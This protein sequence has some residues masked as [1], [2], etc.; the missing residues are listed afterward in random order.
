MADVDAVLAQQMR[1][2]QLHLEA[3]MQQQ[4]QHRLVESDWGLTGT[5]ASI[6]QD[7][8]GLYGD[9]D[10]MRPDEAERTDAYGLSQLHDR[11]DEMQQAQQ[12]E[13]S[14]GREQGMGF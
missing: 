2:L 1:I 11:L 6:N 9:F 3:M 12:Q 10:G 8:E 5:N 4:Q 13:R 14:R 7:V